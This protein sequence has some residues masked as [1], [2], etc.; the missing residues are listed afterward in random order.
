MLLV[1]GRISHW[2]LLEGSSTAHADLQAIGAKDIAHGPGP[3]CRVFCEVQRFARGEWQDPL[4]NSATHSNDERKNVTSRSLLQLC[5][6]GTHVSPLVTMMV[7]TPDGPK[8]CTGDAVG[9]VSCDIYAETL[10]VKIY[11]PPD[12]SGSYCPGASVLQKT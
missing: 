6:Y 5:R 3:R 8:R 1:C 7:R 4:D 12:S 9:D 2:T 11:M 10:W